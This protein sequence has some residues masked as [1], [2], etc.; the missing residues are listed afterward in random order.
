MNEPCS[1]KSCLGIRTRCN[2]SGR[3]LVT[4][5]LVLEILVR[6]TKIFARNMVRLCNN[7]SG[8]KTLVLR[9][10]SLREHN[11]TSSS[12]KDSLGNSQRTWRSPK[13]FA[14]AGRVSHAI[15]L[16][17][18]HHPY[19]HELATLATYFAS[20]TISLGFVI[21]YRHFDTNMCR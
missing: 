4:G 15:V 6:R 1:I 7:W 13:L 10:L 14:V 9:L 2:H 21:L 12:T 5:I 8:L 18:A 16:I 19:S 11:T 3:S 17:K 20:Q